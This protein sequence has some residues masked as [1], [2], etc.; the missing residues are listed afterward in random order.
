MC[1]SFWWSWRCFLY[2]RSYYLSV[3]TSVEVTISEGC[4]DMVCIYALIYNTCYLTDISEIPISGILKTAWWS[5]GCLLPEGCVGGIIGSFW[6][7]FIDWY[8]S[9]IEDWLL[10]WRNMYAA[11]D[12]YLMRPVTVIVYSCVESVI[13]IHIVVNCFHYCMSWVYIESIYA[14]WVWIY[15]GAEYRRF[16]I[17][18]FSILR[19]TIDREDCVDLMKGDCWNFPSCWLHKV[20]KSWD[21][22]WLLVVI[23]YLSLYHL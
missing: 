12:W 5:K 8:I 15:I 22:C 21:N 17:A 18:I 2:F 4:V 23:F 1:S 6:F 3:K 11:C 7:Y 13:F 20:L 19:P 14:A 10:R 9:Y 16:Q